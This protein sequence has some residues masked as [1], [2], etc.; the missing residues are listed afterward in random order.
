M[1]LITSFCAVEI[2]LFGEGFML[3]VCF[4]RSLSEFHVGQG[5]GQGRC[6]DCSQG[7]SCHDDAWR[8]V[9]LHRVLS[10]FFVMFW[11]V[12]CSIMPTTLSTRP[13]HHYGAGAI[14]SVPRRSFWGCFFA[15][16]FVSCSFFAIFRFA[17]LSLW[18][19]VKNPVSTFSVGF[20]IYQNQVLVWAWS[21]Y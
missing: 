13:I 8:R 9:K 20:R 11:F 5:Q 3:W 7:R 4:A 16:T 17:L 12:F 2:F 10:G 14:V 21:D 18:W 1:V 15:T 6:S 19:F